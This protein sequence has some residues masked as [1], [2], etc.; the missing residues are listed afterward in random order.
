MPSNRSEQ[1]VTDANGKKISVILSYRQYRKLLEDIHDLAV[2]AERR[3]EPS[4][5][6]SQLKNKLRKNGRL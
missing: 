5:S 6:F 1:F 3:D 4:I 2:I